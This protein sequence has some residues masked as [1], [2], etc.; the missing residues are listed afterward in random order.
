MIGRGFNAHNGFIWLCNRIDTRKDI[1]GMH[2]QCL[3][4]K[5]WNKW[6]AGVEFK[7]VSWNEAEGKVEFL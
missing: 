3:I 5:A 2:V 7:Q 6:Q 1:T 4:A